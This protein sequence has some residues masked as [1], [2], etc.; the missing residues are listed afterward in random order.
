MLVTR[1]P[2]YVLRTEPGDVDLDRF[3]ALVAAARAAARDGDPAQASA[4]LAE[5][6]ALW[7]GAPLAD[8]A[9]EPFARDALPPLEER[10]SAAL[11]DR[12]DADLALGR[13]AALVPELEAAVRDEPLRERLR[14]QL[15]VALYRSGRQGDA[16][17]AYADARRTLVEELGLEPGP[18]L[19][20]LERQILAQDAGLDP[21]RSPAAP[22]R[23]T[24]RLRRSPA[25]ATSRADGGRRRAGARRDRR[26][27]ALGARRRRPGD[28]RGTA[29][30]RRGHGAA[31]AAA[32]AVDGARRRHGAGTADDARARL[33]GPARPGD[34]RRRGG[35]PGRPAPDDDRGGRGCRVGAER[36]GRHHLARRPDDGGDPHL[37]GRGPSR[38]PRRRRRRRVD[39]RRRLRGRAARRP[40]DPARRRPDQARRRWPGAAGIRRRH[41]RHLARRDRRCASG[42]SARLAASSRSTLPPAAC[43]DRCRRSS[44]TRSRSAA[45]RCGPRRSRAPSFA[46]ILRAGA[47]PPA[48]PSRAVSPP[49]SSTP[50]APSGSAIR[51]R[52]PSGGSTRRAGRRR[53]AWSSRD[54]AASASPRP[55]VRCG[56][57]SG[58]DGTVSRVA[59][60]DAVVARNLELGHEALHVTASGDALW[61]ALGS[62]DRA[63]GDE[64]RRARAGGGAAVRAP[65]VPRTRA[66]GRPR[67]RGRA[68][69]GWLP[70]P[71]QD[72]RR[73][74]GGDA[75]RPRLPGRC[76]RGSA[77]RCATTRPRRA[78]AGRPSAASPTRAPMPSTGRWSASSAPTTAGAR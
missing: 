73:G 1:A 2:G 64:R 43:G 34:R 39:R 27:G 59:G 6:L 21:P 56:S 23:P 25:A 36:R 28:D 51:W 40:D 52:A 69:A 18:A 8:L 32:P 76:V 57:T 19:R 55:A 68:P 50:T 15:M 3:D 42:S 72:R 65:A 20:E 13:H 74:R 5:A 70:P 9:D 41:R 58:L 4:A 78:A 16:L 7:R 60:A 66:A 53:C 47:P 62:P 77:C 75:A 44:S 10:R 37:R 11:E 49:A 35:V 48:C 29:A 12:I 26:R 22:A 14:G 30:R 33:R 46:S 31:A 54:P 17:Q 61:V 38:R 63:A 71:G 24:A 45:A 67:R